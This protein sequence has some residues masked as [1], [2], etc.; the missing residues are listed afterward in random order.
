MLLKAETPWQRAQAYYSLHSWWSRRFNAERATNKLYAD[1]I[2]AG[3]EWWVIDY[4][5]E[6]DPSGAP[7]ATG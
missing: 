3:G 1:V 7:I 5:P 4:T 6:Y 2:E